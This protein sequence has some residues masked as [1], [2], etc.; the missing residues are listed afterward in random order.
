MRA[1]TRRPGYDQASG[2]GVLDVANLAAFFK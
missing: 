2:L 1:T